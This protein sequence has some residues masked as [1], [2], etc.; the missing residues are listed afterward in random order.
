[1]KTPPR[2]KAGDK[3]IVIVQD[4]VNDLKLGSRA[5]I[6]EVADYN[7]KKSHYTYRVKESHQGYYD[8]EL[9]LEHIFYSPLYEALK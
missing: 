3:T 9:E 2:F 8:Y 4:N 6:I 7:T 1:M 5:I